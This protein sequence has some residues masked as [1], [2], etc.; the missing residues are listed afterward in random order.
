MISSFTRQ[1][2]TWRTLSPSDAIARKSDG[3][4]VDIFWEK[5]KR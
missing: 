1:N 2:L 5:I 3:L 4:N